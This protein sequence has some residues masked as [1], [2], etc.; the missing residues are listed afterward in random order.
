MSEVS[1]HP[2]QILTERVFNAGL[3]TYLSAFAYG[4]TTEDDLFFHLEVIC[5]FT[6]V[7]FS[8]FK[9]SCNRLRSLARGRGTPGQPWREPEKVFLFIYLFF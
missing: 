1:A 9:G 3:R 7:I 2:P 5:T 4:T 8:H 6:V